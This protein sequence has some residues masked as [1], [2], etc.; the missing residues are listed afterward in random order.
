MK[1]LR[2]Q[3]GYTLL[4]AVLVATLVLGV[5]IFI[6]SLSQKQY[7]LAAT[8]R[9]STYA[10]YA[11]DTGIECAAYAVRNRIVA[12]TTNAI[13][14]PVV[15]NRTL[16]QATNVLPCAGT[17]AN[18]PSPTAGA[19]QPFSAF[20]D[21]L[22]TSYGMASEVTSGQ[23]LVPLQNSTCALIRFTTGTRSDGKHVTIM[24]SRGYNLCTATG[25]LRT[26]SQ[27]VERALQLTFIDF[28]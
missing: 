14:D 8:A 9:E 6:I 20:N 19:F 2:S 22:V 5:A 13:P 11:A 1:K 21:P 4:F 26:S 24:V 10:F 12:S 15:L 17:T 16:F 27:T 3:R 23:V 28:W 7:L 25:P 18:V